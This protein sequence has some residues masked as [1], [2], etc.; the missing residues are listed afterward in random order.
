M[1]TTFTISFIL[2]TA[3]VILLTY[4]SLYEVGRHAP[5]FIIILSITLTAVSIFVF[6]KLYLKYL[7]RPVKNSNLDGKKDGS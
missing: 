4:F 7:N 2:N 6:F 3:A 5:K 1:K